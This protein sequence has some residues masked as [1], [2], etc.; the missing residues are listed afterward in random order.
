[1][2]ATEVFNATG[3]FQN[4][5]TEEK[6]RAS[7]NLTRTISKVSKNEIS[8]SKNCW[9]ADCSSVLLLLR[10]PLEQFPTEFQVLLQDIQGRVAP[11]E[12]NM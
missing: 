11:N 6:K 5:T 12:L 9:L 4:P 8:Y 7:P 3:L 10:N 2:K 1:M